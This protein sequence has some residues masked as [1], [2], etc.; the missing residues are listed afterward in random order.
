M[1][2]TA[3]GHP[4]TY[5]TP[6]QARHKFIEAKKGDVKASTVRAYKYPTKD[7]VET[8]EALGVEST[9][10]IDGNTLNE[11]KDERRADVKQITLHN[12]VK[13]LR[14]FI[15]FLQRRELAEPGLVDKITVPP[16]DR[17]QAV[18]EERLHLEQYE[19]MYDYLSTYEYA[20]RNH[21]LLHLMWH[22]GCR[23][24]GALALDIGDLDL[25]RNTIKFRHRVDTGTP[26]K[27]NSKSE[28]NVNVSDELVTTL[29]DYIEGRRTDT[30]DEY[31]REPKA[32]GGGS[33]PSVPILLLRALA[34]G[35]N[36]TGEGF[37]PGSSSLRPWSTIPPSPRRT[38]PSDSL[39]S[40]A[41]S[42]RS[43]A[44]LRIPVRDAVTQ[45][46]L[47]YL[48]AVGSLGAG[49]RLD[50]DDIFRTLV[51]GDVVGEVVLDRLDRYRLGEADEGHWH[52]AVA[53][54]WR[55]D[56]L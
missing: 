43:L 28:R 50:H 24:S 26:L 42:N 33:N 36:S 6:R 10:E 11:W 34:R 49:E 53:R 30:L 47:L 41:T 20:S 5:T 51:V 21:A 13:H 38:S 45:F 54:M 14:V 31:D 35:A 9:S 15:R 56:D 19:G 39:V 2:D 27:N 40:G 44:S 22:T 32:S 16:V 55:T 37:E 1:N 18:S 4:A 48:L 25:A 7:F 46:G 52:L 12:N 17:Q 29:R 3:H 8:C 23:I